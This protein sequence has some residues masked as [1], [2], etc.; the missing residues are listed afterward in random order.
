MSSDMDSSGV[1]RLLFGK[2]LTITSVIVSAVFIVIPAFLL[3]ELPALIPLPTFPVPTIPCDYQAVAGVL[4]FMAIIL[5]KPWQLL[6]FPR[7]NSVPF[8]IGLT[9]NARLLHCRKY[10]KRKMRDCLM[11][12]GVLFSVR[13][14]LVF[15]F[16]HHWTVTSLLLPEIPVFLIFGILYVF[17]NRIVDSIPCSKKEY[18]THEQHTAGS[19][20]VLNS[21]ITYMSIAG[22]IASIVAKP[23][24]T[25]LVRMILYIIRRDAFGTVF[26][27]SAGIVVCSAA[28]LM[29]PQSV[30]V[31]ARIVLIAAPVFLVG[32]HHGTISLSVGKTIDCPYWDFT[33][34]QIVLSGIYF[35]AI[36]AAPY[37]LIFILRQIIHFHSADYV[38]IIN[39]IISTIALCTVAGRNFFVCAWEKKENNGGLIIW[40]ASVILCSLM[41]LAG[42]IFSC[43][44]L[45]VNGYYIY[46]SNFTAIRVEG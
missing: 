46:R 1:Y 5:R 26:L 36:V 29:L 27:H 24:H 17:S 25:V 15:I 35:Y 12:L 34:R 33:S 2:S 20:I 42:I 39:F 7:H 16:D 44:L 18:I 45:G 22:I 3:F 40:A 9:W 28:A 11:F 14:V 41:P 4:F 19:G 8:V 32:E 6:R 31:I 21:G 37:V 38:A 43:L 23:V 13:Y 30:E 10:T